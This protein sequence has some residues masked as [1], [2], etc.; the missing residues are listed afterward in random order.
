MTTDEVC[1]GIPVDSDIN[2][3]DPKRTADPALLKWEQHYWSPFTIKTMHNVQTNGNFRDPLAPH[4][5]I[6]D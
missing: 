6:C 2:V 3:L 1:F 4:K 5:L